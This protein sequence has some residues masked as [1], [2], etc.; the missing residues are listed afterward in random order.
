MAFALVGRAKSPRVLVTVVLMES[1]SCAAGITAT[2]TLAIH[3]EMSEGWAK[4][5]AFSP[6]TSTS[7]SLILLQQH[8]PMPRLSSPSL[9]LYAFCVNASPESRGFS[10]SSIGPSLCAHPSHASRHSRHAYDTSSAD[11]DVHALSSDGLSI[12]QNCFQKIQ[13]PTYRCWSK[14]C[15]AC[16]LNFAGRA[17]I[18]NQCV[19]QS[20]AAQT[21][22]VHPPRPFNSQCTPV[23]HFQTQVLQRQS[24]KLIQ[25]SSSAM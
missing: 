16:A 5:N 4:K 2:S 25:R 21:H 15:E 11:T 13:V 1:M 22:P 14:A 8:L 19:C 6:R 23:L 10:Q 18:S 7:A 9:P 24:V 20:E 3:G 12:I 17:K